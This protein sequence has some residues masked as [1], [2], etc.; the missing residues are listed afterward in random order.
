[1]FVFGVFVIA[2]TVGASWT[3]IMLDRARR[4]S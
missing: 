3:Q 4:K 1:M 2:A